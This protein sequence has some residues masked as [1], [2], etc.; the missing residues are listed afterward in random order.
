MWEVFVIIPA[1]KLNIARRLVE[2]D[3][4]E[5]AYNLLY[6]SGY[7]SYDELIES[8]KPRYLMG[9][10]SKASVGSYIIFGSYE[11]DNN[12]SN[13]KEDI[14]WLVLERDDD[15]LLVISRYALDCQK[16]N[17][18]TESVSWE[19]CS[20]RS[21]LNEDFIGFAFSSNEQ[22]LIQSTIIMADNNTNNETSPGNSTNDKVFLLSIKEVNEHFNSDNERQC[23]S[24][25]YA[26]S[27]VTDMEEK[28]RWWLRSPGFLSFDA[29]YVNID[30]VIDEDGKYANYYGIYVRPALWIDLGD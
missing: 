10:Y 18:S 11:Q 12:I 22:S 14:E 19:T 7:E 9:A 8:L 24:T 30:G 27:Q 21:W 6:R 26:K 25:A 17:S 3:D 2:S 20:L 29:A 23:H 13:G 28:C 5:T 16:Y 1:H 15:K 4:Y